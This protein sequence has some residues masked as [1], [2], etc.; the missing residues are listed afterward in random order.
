MQG[1]IHVGVIGEVAET[2]LVL[3]EGLKF[4]RLLNLSTLNFLLITLFFLVFGRRKSKETQLRH[5]L[6]LTV[7]IAAIY[8]TIHDHSSAE[9]VH[10]NVRRRLRLPQLVTSHKINYHIKSPFKMATRRS[11]WIIYG[12][13][14]GG[15]DWK[16]WWTCK[17]F[18]DISTKL[19][20]CRRMDRLEFSRTWGIFRKWYCRS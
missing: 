16:E 12:A 19:G 8:R 15:I 18:V 4:S 10:G 11:Y 17:L 2:I 13:R 5:R 14:Y 7:T 9:I 20:C 1:N 3:C 6:I